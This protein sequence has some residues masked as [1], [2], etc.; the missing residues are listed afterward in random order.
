[1]RSNS[2]SNGPGKAAELNDSQTLPVLHPESCP[3]S[4]CLQGCK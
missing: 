3:C 4:W 1:M 2:F